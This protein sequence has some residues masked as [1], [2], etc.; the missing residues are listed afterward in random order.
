MN[1]ERVTLLLLM[2]LAVQTSNALMAQACTIG[3]CT[4]STFAVVVMLNSLAQV[5]MWG[6]Y[7]LAAGMACNGWCLEKHH[8][9]PHVS[10]IIAGLNST[11]AC[12]CSATGMGKRLMVALA[13]QYGD[14]TVP[15]V[16]AAP[17]LRTTTSTKVPHSIA[18]VAL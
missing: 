13:L 10:Q 7:L 8:P 6:A 12:V 1:H 3:P 11:P 9:S 5:L 17:C 14:L 15:Q 2:P 4:F 18:P 16:A